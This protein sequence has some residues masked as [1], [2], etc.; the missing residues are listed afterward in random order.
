MTKQETDWLLVKKVQ[1]GDK[2]AF[3]FLVTK[4]RRRLL[5]FVFNIVWNPEVAEETVQERF[6]KAYRA[7]PGFR[8]DAAFY[9]W[10]HRIG[11]NAARTSRLHESRTP[12]TCQ[13]GEDAEMDPTAPFL[14]DINTPE[15]ILIARQLAGMIDEA[16][17]NLPEM[18]CM[19]LALRQLEGLN[20]DEVSEVMACPIETVRSRVSR[21]RGFISKRVNACLDKPG[22][23]HH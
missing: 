15:A 21:A 10:L 6:I 2:Q 17:D 5:N 8:G 18:L 23:A 22:R 4:Y 19:A 7:L 9:T 16:M 14:E 3:N 11:I 12:D 1:S 20:Y 13:L